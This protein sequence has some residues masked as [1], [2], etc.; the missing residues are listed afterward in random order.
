MTTFCALSSFTTVVTDAE[1]ETAAEGGGM[2]SLLLMRA[3]SSI[4]EKLL[5][6]DLSRL[7]EGDILWE[8]REERC[9][10]M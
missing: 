7:E 10:I 9:Q 6:V 8:G 3:R 4:V 5:N 1:G 2:G